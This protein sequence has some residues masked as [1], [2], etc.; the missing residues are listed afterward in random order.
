MTIN[1][2]IRAHLNCWICLNKKIAYSANAVL[3]DA[4][5][6]LIFYGVLAASFLIKLIKGIRV[7]Y[8]N[9]L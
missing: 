8:S 5:N 2:N 9:P 4:D 7:F 1:T 6:Y 3:L